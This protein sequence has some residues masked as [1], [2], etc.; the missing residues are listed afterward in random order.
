MTKNGTRITPEGR[1]DPGSDFKTSTSLRHGLDRVF[2]TL[3]ECCVV[4]E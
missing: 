2:V 1:P 3:N 4:W